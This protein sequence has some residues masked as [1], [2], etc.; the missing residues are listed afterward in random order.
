MCRWEPIV[1]R[2]TPQRPPII[3][4][5]TENATIEALTSRIAALEQA[6]LDTKNQ[7]PAGEDERKD[8]AVP[9]TSHVSPVRSLIEHAP[10]STSPPEQPV[11]AVEAVAK[12][13][14]PPRET[15]PRALLD[16]N[17]QA[18]ALA[19]AQ[20]SLAPRTEYV[21]GGSLLYALHKVCRRF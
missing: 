12:S 1:I 2:P 6:L 17:V 19:L 5:S 8:D 7:I 3:P 21:G 16:Y 20:L 11:H 13:S 10:A 18:A 4:A 14:Q 15:G 9:S